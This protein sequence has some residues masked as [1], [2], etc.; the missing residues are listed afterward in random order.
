KYA[1]SFAVGGVRLKEVSRASQ[2]ESL[3]DHIEDSTIAVAYVINESDLEFGLQ[4]TVDACRRSGALAIVD[5][6]LVDPPMRGIREVLKYDPDLVS[7]SGGKGFNGP[8][9]SGLLLGRSDLV[10]R[11]RGLAFPNYGPG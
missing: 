2:S 3:S 6:A 10:S 5:A 11:A 9:A 7:V 4:E 8:N 1:E